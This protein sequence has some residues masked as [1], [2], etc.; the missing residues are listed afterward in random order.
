MDEETAA[1]AKEMHRELAAADHLLGVDAYRDT[2]VIFRL[3]VDECFYVG[4]MGTNSDAET[5]AAEEYR[6]RE[7]AGLRS[8]IWM[9]IFSMKEER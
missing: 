7:A 9:D 2:D 6:Y 5:I 4:G 1:S 8:F 3:V